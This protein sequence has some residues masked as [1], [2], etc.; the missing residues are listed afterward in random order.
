[1][2]P[3]DLAPIAR[4]AAA[5]IARTHSW[6][7][8]SELEQEAWAAML[9]AL[10]HVDPQGVNA[11]GY[12]YRAALRAVKQAAWGLSMP[13]TMPERARSPERV[14][15]LT[16][17]AAPEETLCA[18]AAA[19]PAVDAVVAQ[20]ERRDRLAALVAH[21]LAHGRESEAV[22]AVLC[23]DL[24][25]AEAAEAYGLETR[26]LYRATEAATRWLRQNARVPAVR[27]VL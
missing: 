14:R 1:M 17:A 16:A 2:L 11:K 12:L 4:Q 26:R 23:G 25:P 8:R 27:E 13:V 15:A 6:L 5:A 19:V 10:P 18:V 21:K 7:D 3:L 9:G 22:S 24:E 20:K